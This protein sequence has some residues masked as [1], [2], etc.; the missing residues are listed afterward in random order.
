MA[1]SDQTGSAEGRLYEAWQSGELSK[2]CFDILYDIAI[3]AFASGI[4]GPISQVSQEQLG[5]FIHWQTAETI[6]GVKLT[7]LAVMSLYD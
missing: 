5:R 7:V 3:D 2:E 6:L 4:T 1:V